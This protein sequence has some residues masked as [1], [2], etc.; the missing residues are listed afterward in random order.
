MR[1]TTWGEYAL[2]CS[3]HLAHRRGR[4]PI[5]GRELASSERLPGDYVEQILLRLRRAGIVTSVRGAHGGYEL[6]RD[7]SLI[8][9]REVLAAAEHSTFDLNCVSHPVDES[10][11]SET[12]SCSI[13][14]VWILLQNKID[15]VLEGVKL[16]DL[17][18]EEREVRERVGLPVLYA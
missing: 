18:Q 3:V 9:V 16:A 6:A 14:P 5:N 4:G 13:R 12:R 11:C 1:I 8:S 17:L 2:I 15:E 10:R 7:P